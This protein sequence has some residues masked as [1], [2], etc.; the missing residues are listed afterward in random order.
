MTV[1]GV[2]AAADIR[3]HE[4]V[5]VDRLDLADRLLDDAVRIVGAG[6][7]VV[8]L[9]R[10]AEQQHG[11]DTQRA[12]VGDFARK[13]VERELELARHRADLVTDTFPLGHEQ[14]VDEVGGVERCLAHEIAHRG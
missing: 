1:I 5:R 4:H 12:Q 10:D 7:E 3:D 2:L 6:R 9:G 8:L 14:G 13:L 11:R